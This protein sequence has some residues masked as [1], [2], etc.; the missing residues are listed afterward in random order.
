MYKV[1]FSYL[2]HIKISEKIL[3]IIFKR[4]YLYTLWKIVK[5]KT[6]HFKYQNGFFNQ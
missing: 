2:K 6:I 5:K 4:K 3:N 1:Y